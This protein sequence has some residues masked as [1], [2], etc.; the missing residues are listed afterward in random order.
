[1]NGQRSE[2]RTPDDR[3]Q[4]T[5][6]S[7]KSEAKKQASE[8]DSLTARF[9]RDTESTEKKRPLKIAVG[10]EVEKTTSPVFSLFP[11]H[12]LPMP[13]HWDPPHKRCGF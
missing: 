6:D 3:W 12:I 8:K 4:M 1:M 5:E 10:S 9:A 2:V 11:S 7:K 13:R